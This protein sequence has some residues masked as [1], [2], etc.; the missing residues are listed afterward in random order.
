MSY[1]KLKTTSFCVGSRQNSATISIKSDITRTGHKLP[2][3]KCGLCKRKKP[4]IVSDNT[5]QA[6]DILNFSEGIEKAS[7]KGGKKFATHVVEILGRG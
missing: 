2:I 4:T 6:E 7:A 3:G 5:I 1:E